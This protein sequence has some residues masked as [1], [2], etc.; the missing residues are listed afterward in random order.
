MDQVGRLPTK[1]NSCFACWELAWFGR[2]VYMTHLRSV[3]QPLETHSSQPRELECMA[4]G[5]NPKQ[6]QLPGIFRERVPASGQRRPDAK[7][8]GWW[9]CPIAPCSQ[10]PSLN[11]AMEAEQFFLLFWPQTETGEETIPPTVCTASCRQPILVLLAQQGD[12]QV[13]Q[14]PLFGGSHAS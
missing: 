4:G 2:Y 11:Q 3:S 5:P 13:P 1:G 14:L 7:Q 8:E 9:T 10:G 12:M 6:L